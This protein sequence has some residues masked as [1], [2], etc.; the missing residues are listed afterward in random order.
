MR[1]PN[2]TAAVLLLAATIA[3]GAP[4]PVGGEGANEE[5]QASYDVRFDAAWSAQ[6]HPRDF[7]GSAHFSRL[8]GGTHGPGV[9][10]WQPGELASRG[11]QDMAERG[12]VQPLEREVAQAIAAG[13]AGSVVR[14]TNVPQSPGTATASLTVTREFPRVTLVT[15]IAPSPDWFVGTR[16]VSLLERGRW[17]ERKVVTL[18]A[19]DAGT[20]SGSTFRSPDQPTLPPEPIARIEGFPFDGVPIGTLTFERTDGAGPEALLLG[21][22]GRFAVRTQ[23][24]TAAG[25]TG[26][27]VPVP[28]TEDTGYFWFFN[29]T[30]I[31]MMIKVLDACSHAGRFWVFAGGLTNTGVEILVEDTEA[32]VTRTYSNP[33]G[34]PFQPIQDTAGFNTCP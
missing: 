9:G 14:G 8:V 33:L 10:F 32:G 23:W 3:L 2:R 29:P 12:Q 1:L 28:L 21:D 25:S 22:D 20:D 7:P 5:P 4:P 30:N 6:T 11:I 34:R 17:L 24:T 15:M 26:F 27:G 19:Y 16:G 31:E 13:L 18:Y